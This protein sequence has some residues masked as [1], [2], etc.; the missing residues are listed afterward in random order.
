MG[1]SVHTIEIVIDKTD[2]RQAGREQMSF[3]FFLFFV[4]FFNKGLI[5]S[6]IK[7]IDFVFLETI[8]SSNHDGTRKPEIE[9]VCVVN[10]FRGAFLDSPVTQASEGWFALERQGVRRPELC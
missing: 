4:F 6:V 7:L 2:K 8:E 3:S 10:C 9:P 1:V 5:I